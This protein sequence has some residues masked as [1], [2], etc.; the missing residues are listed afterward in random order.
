MLNSSFCS[1]DRDYDDKTM[2]CITRKSSDS[3]STPGGTVCSADSGGPLVCQ[4]KNKFVQEGIAQS[5]STTD[6]LGWCVGPGL[7]IRVS[8]YVDWINDQMKALGVC[9]DKESVF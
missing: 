7:F 2:F 5:L 9:E 6:R 1:K 8:A 3:K 4:H